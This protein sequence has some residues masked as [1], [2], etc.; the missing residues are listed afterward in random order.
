MRSHHRIRFLASLLAI[1]LPASLHAAD[2]AEPWQAEYA[3]D[4]A[5]ADHVLGLWH[6]NEKDPAADASGKSK[7]GKFVGATTSKEGRFGPALQSAPGYPVEDKKHALVVPD[8][9]HLSPSGPFT[10]EMWICP[11]KELNADYPSAF[12][13]DKKYVSDRDY[14]LVLGADSGTGRVLTAVLGFGN[15]SYSFH[16]KRI[17][18]TAGRWCH[19]AFT[20]DG[21]GTG[22]FFM[23]GLPWGETLEPSCERI[24]PGPLP[25]SIG[26]R[27]GSY[28]H[29][30]P[31]KI[32]EVRITKGVRRFGPVRF[33]CASDRTVFRR[34]EP[35]APLRFRLTNLGR[36]P[37]EGVSAVVTCPGHEPRRTTIKTLAPAEST[38]LE[39]TF[40]TTLRPDVYDVTVGV[41]S[42]TAK[43]PLASTTQTIQ[44]MPRPTPERMPVLMWG[45]YSEASFKKEAAR[46]KEIGFTHV[47]GLGADASKIWEAQGPVQPYDDERMK[48]IKEMLDEALRQDI[49]ISASLAPVR[50]FR[51]REEFSRIDRNGN[52]PKRESVCALNPKLAPFCRNVGVSVAQAFGRFPAFGAALLHT[53]VRDSAR[54]C[55]HEW[56]KKAFRDFA[57]FDIPKE[58]D[59]PRG[60]DYQKLP[61]FPEDRVIPDDNPILTYYRWYWKEGDGWNRLNSELH[62][63]LKSTG[64]TDLWTFHDP[65]VRVASVYGSGGECDVISQWTYSYPDPIRIGLATDELLAMAA[66]AKHDQQV[67]KMTQIIWYRSQTAPQP[68]SEKDAVP[69]KAAWEKKIPDARFITIA[70]MHLREAFWTKIA[71]PIKGIMYHGWQSLVQTESTGAYRY[72][73]PETKHELARLIRTV[74]RPLGPTLRTV[75]G[76][77]SDIAVLE[78]FSSEMFAGRGTYGWCGSRLGDVYHALMYAGCQPEIIFDETI[79]RRGLDG[80]KVLVLVDCDVLTKTVVRRINAFQKTGGVV[81][82][83]DRLSPAVKPDLRIQ[84]TARTGRADAD[85]KALLALAEEIRKKL[86]G[87]HADPVRS[88]NP[89]VIPYRRRF[90]GTDYLFLVNDTREYGD[91]VGHHGIVMENGLGASTTITLD[92]ADGA[93]YDLVDAC[94]VPIEQKEGRLTT[95]LDF[96]PC[97]GRLLMVTPKPIA[98]VTVKHAK[99]VNRGETVHCEIAVVDADGKPVDAVVPLQVRVRDASARSAEGSGYYAA[100]GGKCTLS[101]DIAKND[102]YGIWTIDVREGASGKKFLSTFRVN[103]PQPWPPKKGPVD[104]QLANP[105][106]PKG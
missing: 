105:E 34:M 89:E 1:L 56:D 76:A 23:N 50:A 94:P 5:T 88:S 33:E 78:S 29:G 17:P 83:D 36:G 106:Q 98:R 12:L 92:R 18:L 49:T 55:F 4:D 57:G 54:P 87:K 80:F 77:K 16:S 58:V 14:Q 11:D 91:Y 31:G 104:E 75:P 9:P 59:S 27:H 52:P 95:T 97:G 79:T 81:L 84:P 40:D 30:F 65:A 71:R 93:A 102:D 62:E 51:G 21:L 15:H 53:E 63:G 38:E 8:A 68:K 2:L 67:M 10:V 69:Y 41:F 35:P 48:K 66:G 13:L 43:D 73:H 37:L 64:R 26:D 85:K 74:V 20:Y 3:G 22:S 42:E 70:P 25:L 39:F 86:A 47:L 103:R 101:L 19:V 96:A 60:V 99:A 100:P 32:D 28:Y 45:G 24:A 46:L 6:F 61:D 7:P 82:A 44:L 90:G 72:T